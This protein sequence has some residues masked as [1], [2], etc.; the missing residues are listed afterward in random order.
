MVN[1]KL[2]LVTLVGSVLFGCTGCREASEKQ[3]GANQSNTELLKASPDT[4]LILNHKASTSSRDNKERQINSVKKMI[5]GNSLPTRSV[6]H[7]PSKPVRGIYVSGWIAGSKKR[8]DQLL[9]LMDKTDLN[10]MVIDVKND[11]GK[12]TYRSNLAQIQSIGADSNPVIADIQQLISRL[13]EKNIYVIGRIVTF[14]D[15]LYA[16]NYPAM[17]LQAKSG[18]VWH[19]SQ[20]H[21][22]LD[23]YQP[24]VHFYNQAIAKEAAEFGF[25]EIQFDYVR[26]PDNGAKVDKE[27]QY[28]ARNNKTKAE[29][30]GVFLHNARESV[31]AAGARISADVFGL[32]TSADNDMGI[33]QTWRTVTSSVD[34]I[35]PMIYPSHYSEGMY[36]VRQPDLNP[37][38]IIKHAMKDAQQRNAVIQKEGRQRPAEIRPWLQSFTATWIHPHQRYNAEQVLKQVEAVKAQGIKQYLLWSSNC[39]YDY[40]S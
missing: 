18:G 2:L 17:A 3:Y 24:G 39:K 9:A 1:N 33:G 23:P 27:V 29:I 36:G 12:L 4:H 22:W 20:G 31:H 35:S 8:L 10:T 28:Y 34:V 25:D 11:Y 15:P 14:K 40:H 16:R 6:V 26:F 37:A 21:A 13:K 30:I 5:K 7:K 32:V 19:D 38:A